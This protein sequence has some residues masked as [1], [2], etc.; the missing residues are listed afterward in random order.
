MPR[1]S[2]GQLITYPGS[3]VKMVTKN[4]MTL[5]RQIQG[6]LPFLLAQVPD[7]FFLFKKPKM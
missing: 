4:E 5:I 3:N 7:L 2:K 1:I 6:F